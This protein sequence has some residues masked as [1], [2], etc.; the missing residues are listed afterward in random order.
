MQGAVVTKVT[1][2]CPPKSNGCTRRVDGSNFRVRETLESDLT[3]GLK[4][5]EIGELA[6]RH[7]S[8]QGN[9]GLPVGPMRRPLTRR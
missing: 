5:S 3:E 4:S 1:V 2:E 8:L 7:L 6:C 9:N